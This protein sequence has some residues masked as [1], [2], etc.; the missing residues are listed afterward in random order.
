M[1]G[2]LLLFISIVLLLLSACSAQ[3]QLLEI[4]FIDTDAVF[5]MDQ[6]SWE[7]YLST[8][9]CN[10]CCSIFRIRNSA[11]AIHS[12]ILSNPMWIS[13]NNLTTNRAIP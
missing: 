7:N 6:A 2:R 4:P 5:P 9:H 1:K 8:E 11:F 13:E 3:G 10:Y 12:A